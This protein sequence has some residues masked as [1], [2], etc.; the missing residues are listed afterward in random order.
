MNWRPGVAGLSG[1]FAGALAGHIAVTLITR[2]GAQL[3][4][5]GPYGPPMQFFAMSVYLG[6]LYASIAGALS[7]QIRPALVGFGSA[8]LPIA[9]P[10][11]ILTHWPGPLRAFLH[12]L[13]RSPAITVRLMRALHV[14]NPIALIWTIAVLTVYLVATWGTTLALGALLCPARRWLGAILA[15]VGSGAGYLALQLFAHFIPLPS[16][17]DPTSFIPAPLDLLTGLLIGAGMGAGIGWAQDR[18]HK[19]PS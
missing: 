17:W 3:W 15:A 2:L 9:L 13:A 1:G 10:M 16:R 14:L 7:R 4:L 6:F 18:Q 5:V 8:C 19:E 11:T 12:L